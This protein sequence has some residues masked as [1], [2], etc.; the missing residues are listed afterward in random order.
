MYLLPQNLQES[1][2]T[3]KDS[4]SAQLKNQLAEV[5]AK[6]GD[7][8]KEVTNHLAII[9]E[10]VRMN[11]CREREREKRGYVITHYSAM[12]WNQF[13][14]LGRRPWLNWKN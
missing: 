2:A 4:D 13:N 8:S 14:H 10:L 11:V 6:L 3:N 1:G 7:K 5:Q 12:K 9:S